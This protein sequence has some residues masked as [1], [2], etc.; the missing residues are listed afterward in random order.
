MAC[1]HSV[2]HVSIHRMEIAVVA[3][4]VSLSDVVSV[5]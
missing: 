1:R 4:Q 5:A 2:E 3:F